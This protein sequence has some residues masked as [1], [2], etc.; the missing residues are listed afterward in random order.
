MVPTCQ[1]SL[2]A[3]GKLKVEQL[4][5]LTRLCPMRVNS[6]KHNICVE[7]LLKELHRALRKLQHQ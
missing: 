1:A 5:D 2:D 4:T 6:P 7:L 3:D